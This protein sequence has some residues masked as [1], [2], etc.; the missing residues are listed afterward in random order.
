MTQATPGKSRRRL[1][2]RYVAGDRIHRLMVIY[3]RLVVRRSIP[4]LTAIDY[5]VRY[6][7]LERAAPEKSSRAVRSSQ[8]RTLFPLFR[9]P[10]QAALFQTQ[11]QRNRAGH[12]L[13]GRQIAAWRRDLAQ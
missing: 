12:R 11:Y 2:I 8:R 3:A 1:R 4:F 7:S 13:A 9:L 6:A 10:L 5:S